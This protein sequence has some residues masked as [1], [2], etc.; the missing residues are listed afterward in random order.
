MQ[1]EAYT[2]MENAYAHIER[3]SPQ[4]AHKWA[5]GLMDAIQSLENFPNACGHAP[6]NAYFSQ[7]IR[8]LIYGRGLNAYRILFTV[9]ADTVSVLFIRHGAQDVL[10]PE[11]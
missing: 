4:N 10:R 3:D 9:Q 5:V 7:E 8:Q 11:E 1:P 6:E 2:A